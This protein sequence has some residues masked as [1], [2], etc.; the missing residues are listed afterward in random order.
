[1]ISS[2][3]SSMSHWL[4]SNVLCSFQLF[5]YVLLLLLLLSSS[6][7][8]LCRGL[9]LFFFYLVRLALCPKIW[10]ILEKIP[11]AAEKNVYCAVARWNSP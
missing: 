7:I 4:L 10:S 3:I 1:L 8:A 11:W 2:L 6:F 5:A 9:F